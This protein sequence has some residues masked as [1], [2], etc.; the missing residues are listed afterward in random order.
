MKMGALDSAH[1]FV[2][3]IVFRPIYNYDRKNLLNKYR[4]NRYKGVF[5]DI[6]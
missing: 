2:V 5:F 6:V 4:N 3:H 1:F